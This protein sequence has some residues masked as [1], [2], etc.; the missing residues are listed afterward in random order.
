PRAGNLL[1][2]DVV[3]ASG[4]K[5]STAKV[6]VKTFDA[7]KGIEAVKVF[8]MRRGSLANQEGVETLVEVYSTAGGSKTETIDFET[9]AI[10][11]DM[12]GGE[13]L[14][15]GCKAPGRV[16]IM[17]ADGELSLLDQF[18][19]AASVDREQRQLERMKK[20]GGGTQG[21]GKKQGGGIGKDDV[22]NQGFE[23][24]G[25]KGRRKK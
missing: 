9:D 8:D 17:R 3:P 18:A 2:S 10:C 22:W 14:P 15:M 11:L 20:A 21:M 1:A 5:E 25:K 13:K 7:E 23:D 12:V 19:D 4:G 6:M 24:G 16:M